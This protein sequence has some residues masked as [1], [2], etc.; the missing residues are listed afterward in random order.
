MTTSSPQHDREMLLLR[1]SASGQ[2]DRVLTAATQ[3]LAE[4]PEEPQ[5]HLHVA[6]ALINL[7]RHAQ[8]EPHLA[9]A[10]AHRPDNA[11]AHRFMAIVQFELKNYRAADLAIHEAIALAPEEPL[12]W[13]Q[14]AWMCHAQQDL[15]NGLKWATRALELAP[16]NADILNLY[17]I[18]GGQTQSGGNVMEEVLALDPEH[19]LAHNNLG[20]DY[21]NA[22]NYAKAEEC[23]QRALMLQPTLKVARQNLFVAIKH[24]DLFYRVL[25]APRDFLIW[26]RKVTFG[27][28]SRKRNPAAG[29]FG[30]LIWILIFK[31]VIVGFIFW[32]GLVW[33]LVK[34]YEFLVIGDLRKK[35]GEV[36]AN[37]GGVFGYRRWSLGVRMAIFAVALVGFWAL[38]RWLLNA[39]GEDAGVVLTAT[40]LSG[41]GIYFGSRALKGGAARYHSWRR[42]RRLRTLENS[43][44]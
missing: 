23:F 42:A 34:F 18:C 3:W 25:C 19:A 29:A 41:V 1:L 13:Y 33:P 30:F 37:R 5:A 36:G 26:I 22:E 9:K 2:W 11:N 32:L 10:L 4:E 31:F 14:L 8:A 39:S 38:V 24:R 43:P 40:V 27:D 44:G 20:A 12:N 17:A 21:L 7:E 6:L 15:K 35:A 28:E 16:E